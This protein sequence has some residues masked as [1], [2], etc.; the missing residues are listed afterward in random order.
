MSIVYRGQWTP[1]ETSQLIKDL[2]KNVEAQANLQ[3]FFFLGS[4]DKSLMEYLSLGSDRRKFEDWIAGLGKEY[5]LS[6]NA[7][8]IADVIQQREWES[9]DEKT[10]LEKFKANG[11]IKEF[12]LELK[13]DEGYREDFQE[14]L[15]D[16]E[17]STARELA[18]KLVELPAEFRM[19]YSFGNLHDNI[20]FITLEEA[21]YAVR[22]I[23]F[24]E[25]SNSEQSNSE[26]EI[27]A[28]A[29]RRIGRIWC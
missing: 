23:E 27:D 20:Y 21:E 10:L 22:G 4:N 6:F 7:Q 1:E 13:N 15:Q 14:W 24:E 12:L 5:G 26:Q 11:G 25:D 8:D 16:G 19:K 2:L 18:F 17:I 9:L 28:V 3:K 29:Y